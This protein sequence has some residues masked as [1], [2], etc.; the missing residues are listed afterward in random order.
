MFYCGL[1]LAVC[2]EGCVDRPK[3]SMSEKHR[4]PN[5][6]QAAL[7][8][9]RI[10]LARKRNF[11]LSTFSVYY[12]LQNTEGQR[13]TPP[14]LQC[15]QPI[16]DQFTLNHNPMTTGKTHSANLGFEAKLW[17]AADKLRNN[18]DAAEYKH[19]VLGLILK[20]I[21]DTFRRDLH[22]DLRADYV[23][24]NPPF[25]DSDWFRKDDDVRWQFGVL[26]KDKTLTATNLL[27]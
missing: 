22:P 8:K 13:S 2:N 11:S 23:L 17:L 14:S 3:H 15:P 9:W 26:P 27:N 20:Y 25:N 24:S 19:V 1:R 18:M 4:A 5:A 7:Q 16:T 10:H 6:L 21:S 12:L